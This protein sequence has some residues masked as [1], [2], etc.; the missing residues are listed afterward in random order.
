MHIIR[1]PGCSSWKEM[2]DFRMGPAYNRWFP[3]ITRH[4]GTAGPRRRDWNGVVLT[5]KLINKSL[6]NSCFAEKNGREE[7]A[8]V[9]R[10]RYKY[11]IELQEDCISGPVTFGWDFF[12]QSLNG[13]GLPRTYIHEARTLLLHTGLLGKQD[14]RKLTVR[15]Y[16]DVV[17]VKSCLGK[18]RDILDRAKAATGRK[19][20]KVERKYADLEKALINGEP[21]WRWLK[22]CQED[23]DGNP[24][25]VVEWALDRD[26]ASIS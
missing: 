14:W 21:Y 24:D 20:S 2:R 7:L 4:I 10:R 1:C 12:Y 5:D 8:K 22:A 17:A 6:C 26:G 23:V 9:L 11:C 15:N 13:A 3:T 18:L 16:E 25:L 19:I